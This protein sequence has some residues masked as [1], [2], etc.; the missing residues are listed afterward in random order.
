MALSTTW[1]WRPRVN[2]FVFGA[3]VRHHHD[4]VLILIVPE[5]RGVVFMLKSRMLLCRSCDMVFSGDSSSFVLVICKIMHMGTSK[6]IKTL[7]RSGAL[8]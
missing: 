6:V 8:A 5:A 2:A 4:L 7:I 3:R 1:Q